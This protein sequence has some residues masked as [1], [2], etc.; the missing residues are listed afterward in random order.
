MMTKTACVACGQHLCIVD[1]VPTPDSPSEYL[2]QLM[3]SAIPDPVVGPDEACPHC[4]EPSPLGQPD[5][6]VF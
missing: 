2:H 6:P 3:V 4:G 1:N 5:E